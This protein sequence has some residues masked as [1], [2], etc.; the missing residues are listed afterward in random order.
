MIIVLAG[1][2]IAS[3][4]PWPANF[5]PM[6]LVNTWVPPLVGALV[7]LAVAIAAG[8]GLGY[9]RPLGRSSEWALL[10]FAPWLLIGPGVGMLQHF[11]FLREAGLIG[12]LLGFLPS[13]MISVAAVVGF[14]LLFAGVRRLRDSGAPSGAAIVPVLGV[15][16]TSLGLLWVVQAQSLVIGMINGN[17]A[18]AMTGPIALLTAAAQSRTRME[19]VPHSLNTPLP[20]IIL[21]G[22]AS[23]AVQALCLDRLRLATGSATAQPAPPPSATH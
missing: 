5:S 22:L 19:D 2:L 8:F 9:L 6:I 23:I 13:T 17:R 10:I 7:Q 21:L 14:T 16:L 4:R 1:W 15:A 3:V 12:T 20:L 11:I 18:D